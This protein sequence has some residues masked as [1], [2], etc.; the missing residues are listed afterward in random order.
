LNNGDGTFA[1]QVQLQAGTG[2]NHIVARDFDGDGDLDLAV[3][4]FDNNGTAGNTVSVFINQ[5]VSSSA[6]DEP[7]LPKI[8]SLEQNYPN[9]FNPKT[10][11]QFTIVNRQLTIVTVYDVL[12][13]EVATLVNEVKGRGTHAVQFDGS[14]LASGVYFYRLTAGN[15]VQTRKLL[16]LR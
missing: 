1:P 10:K 13:R 15:F 11:I 3:E 7:I 14:N 2:T 16:L 6:T 4:N 5:T 12:G 8:Y 9:P